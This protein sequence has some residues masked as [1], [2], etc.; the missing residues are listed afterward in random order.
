[1][2]ATPSRSY[3]WYCSEEAGMAAEWGRSATSC[4]PESGES[5]FP[6][7][8]VRDSASWAARRSSSSCSVRIAAAAAAS[9]SAEP[10]SSASV[11][12]F[13]RA[14]PAALSS[15]WLSLS[16]MHTKVSRISVE[17][18][19]TLTFDWIDAPWPKYSGPLTAR[20]CA[21]EAAAAP[22]PPLLIAAAAELPGGGGA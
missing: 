12:F 4:L 13:R 2:A 8:M 5:C 14:C 6:P 18:S 10:I 21:A 9:A 22:P 16:G 20:L 17:S 7:G 11:I 1:M 19:P 3:S 15:R